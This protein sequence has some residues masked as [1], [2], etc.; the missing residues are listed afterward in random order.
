MTVVPFLNHEE[1]LVAAVREYLASEARYTDDP[2]WLT[3][4]D[5]ALLAVARIVL[6]RVCYQKYCVGEDA[7]GLVVDKIDRLVKALDRLGC[8][9]AA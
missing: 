5:F 3:K 7:D 6:M 9:R 8:Q 2:S 1:K 4:P